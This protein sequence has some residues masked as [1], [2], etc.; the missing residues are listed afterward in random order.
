MSNESRPLATQ[1]MFC[2]QCDEPLHMACDEC[3][4][5]TILCSECLD[6]FVVLVAKNELP[7]HYRMVIARGLGIT[8]EKNES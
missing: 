6:D 5:T 2:I 8:T 7:E 4:I 3:P 1:G